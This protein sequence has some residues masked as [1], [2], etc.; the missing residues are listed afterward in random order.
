MALSYIA[1]NAETGS[2]LVTMPTHTTGDVLLALA[3][4]VGSTVPTLPAGWTSAATHTSS[5]AAR[6]AI[7][8]AASAG[9]TSG[10]WTNAE[11]LA[12][13]VFRGQDASDVFGGS[14]ATAAGGTGTNLTVP[15]V[16]LDRSDNT[17]WMVR[18]HTVA[19]IAA[20]IGAVT[21][22]Y[23][24]RA[25]LNDGVSQFVFEDS[26]STITSGTGGSSSALGG[27][28]TRR[29]YAAEIKAAPDAFS[30][31][32]FGRYGVRGPIR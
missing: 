9:E 8:T 17:S 14:A 21:G 13:W 15:T 1:F 5:Q 28:Y 18:A 26:G 32:A 11:A 6:W 4:Q 24:R 27:T 7:K 10:T 30:T 3:V 22:G 25:L 23:T 20:T 29:G 19:S 12:I 31:P 2:S 16:T